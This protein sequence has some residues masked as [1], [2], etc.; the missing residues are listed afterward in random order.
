MILRQV[1]KVEFECGQSR[2]WLCFRDSYRQTP[3]WS[4]T[5][6][7]PDC[8]QSGTYPETAFWEVIDQ[9]PTNGHQARKPALL[10]IG[11]TSRLHSL[12]D[13]GKSD[14][15]LGVRRKRPESMAP[16]L[17]QSAFSSPVCRGVVRNSGVFRLFR[18]WYGRISL[19]F[20]LCGGE[21]GIRTPGTAFDRTTV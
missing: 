6:Q 20:R 8:Q 3:L 15:G 7:L 19:L 11:V 10:V 12:E 1:C 21:G 4:V 14:Y 5:G 2:S 16:R 17:E 18:H 13:F 9:T